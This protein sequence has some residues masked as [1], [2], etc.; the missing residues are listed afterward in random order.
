M[1]VKKTQVILAIII[2]ILVVSV[3]AAAVKTFRV[4]ETELVRISVESVD[5]DNDNLTYYYSAPLDERGEWQTGYDDAGEY[6]LTIIASDGIDQS[7]VQVQLIIE[8]KNQP[9]IITE[10][11]IQVKEMELVDLKTIVEDPDGDKLTYDFPAPFDRDGIWTPGYDDAGEETIAFTASDGEFTVRTEVEIIISNAN[12]PPEISEI[13]SKKRDIVVNEGDNLE[14]YVKAVDYDDDRLTYSWQ[15]DK[16]VISQDHSDNYYFDY[17]SAGEKK[18]SV[19]INDSASIVTEE[20]A[21]DIK[22]TNRRP[23]INHVPIMVNEGEKVML[24]FPDTDADGDILSYTYELPL[25]EEGEWHTDYNDAGKYFLEVTVNDGKLE[26]SIEIEITVIDQDRAPELNLAQKWEAY[27]DE[28]LKIKL[29]VSDPDNDNLSITIKNAPIGSKL[30]GKTFSWKPSYDTIT[31]KRGMVSNFLNYL[32]LEKYFIKS[33]TMEL[34][35]DACSKELCCSQE[36]ELTVY[37]V[38]RAPFFKNLTS[39]TVKE[40][41]LVKL[42][43]VAVDPDGDLLKYSYGYP[44]GNDGK[45]KTDYD[46]RDTY[47]VDVTA[48]DGQ[49]SV[50]KQVILRVTKNNRAPTVKVQDDEIAVNENQ[51]LNFD[52]K[53]SDPD[54]E[55]LDLYLENLPS[56][57]SFRKWTFSWKPDY[58]IVE[59]KTDR[60]SNN[61]FSASNYLNR[62]YNSEKETV[63]LNFVVADENFDVIHPVKVTIKNVNRAPEIIDYLPSKEVSAKVNQPVIFHVAAKDADNDKLNYH[64]YLG[65]NQ[66]RV[67]DTDTIERTFLTPGRKKVKVTVSD[68]RDAAEKEWYVNVES[69][70][71]VY[72]VQ[73]VPILRPVSL[74]VV[75]GEIV[76]GKFYVAEDDSKPPA[77]V[78]CTLKQPQPG[79]EEPFTVGIYTVEN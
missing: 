65:M 15:L 63:W 44:L 10:D 24:D 53:A 38:N 39:I 73:P 16:E 45:W 48:T 7:A 17:D 2:L 42:E 64:W 30:D 37:N 76:T 11:K 75:T 23:E 29:D 78:N 72:Y 1:A 32:R 79:L 9:P 51:E 66:I 46:D 5:P 36:V 22:N 67:E 31:R 52:V 27:E 8:N 12:Q 43:S 13:F 58:S 28:L 33:K 18:L 6:N 4:Q 59:N 69:G 21:I 25:N 34:V 14:F 71:Q 35:V 61:L 19:V 50:T 41:E 62:K 20:W 47:Y 55:E 3:T 56:G 49:I 60:W 70:E 74:K 26:E 77:E 40:T 57:A 54:T 68:G